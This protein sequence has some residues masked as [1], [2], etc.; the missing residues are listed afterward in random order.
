MNIILRY[1]NNREV[2]TN[3]SELKETLDKLNPHEL[4]TLDIIPYSVLIDEPVRDVLWFVKSCLG[5][6]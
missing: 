6:N 4:V 3:L 2:F 1:K 5:K